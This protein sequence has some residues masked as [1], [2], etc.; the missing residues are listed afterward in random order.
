MIAT[1]I[2]AV[3][4]P[5]ARE[6]RRS[7]A[8]WAFG[9]G[10]G[11]SVAAPGALHAIRP[12]IERLAWVAVLPRRSQQ[13]D[14]AW[15]SALVAAVA[16]AEAAVFVLRPRHG[17]IAPSSVDPLEYFDAADIERARRY[18]RGQLALAAM[19]GLTEAA[20]LVWL[21]RRGREADRGGSDERPNSAEAGAKSA[22]VEDPPRADGADVSPA[23]A[24]GDGL[25]E[26]DRPV[27]LSAVG[28]RGAG[29]SL[30]LMLVPLPFGALMRT[31]ALRVG[32]ATQSWR[33]WAGD[34]ARNGALGAAFTAGGAVIV[35]ALM[36][37]FGSEWWRAAAGGSVGVAVVVTLVGPVVLDPIFND[38][39]PLPEGELRRDVLALAQRAGVRVGEV[40]QVDAS[41]RTSAANA[42]VNG[43]GA[44][45]RIVLYDTL[46]ASFTP[47]ET[48]TV[49]AHEL[50]HVRYRDVPRSLIFLG[51]VAPAG[52]RAVAR[53]AERLGGS[54][55][56]ELPALAL[57]AAVVSAALGVV[58]RQLSRA[59]E[60]RADAFSLELT[61]EADAFV[62]FEQRIVRQNLADP[63]SP[64]WLS[65]L[66]GTHPPIVQR[67]G[68]AAAYRAGERATP[69]RRPRWDPRTPAGS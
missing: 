40:F 58:A 23:H 11:S 50:A 18:G 22:E 62:S 59:I 28:A 3:D 15:L 30:A 19:G 66:L 9:R 35:T 68:I 8:A 20:L 33:G 38:F 13:P 64:R 2:D 5:T 25:P 45:R 60:R 41:R 10:G 51:L 48:R 34:V 7:L 54:A 4:Q 39:E 29:L 17:L 49:V 42:Y 37:R 56:P 67:L 32:L 44:S 55:E 21:V 14:R 63:D 53:L 12:P 65:A 52:T 27:A 16:A 47:A 69:P 43:L 31:R 6:S 24:E 1:F 36:R 26:A 46:L 57:A 61:G